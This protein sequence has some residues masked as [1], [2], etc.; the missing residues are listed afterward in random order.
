MREHGLGRYARFRTR[1]KFGKFSEG[2]ILAFVREFYSH[3]DS[4][5]IFHFRNVQTEEVKEWWLHDDEPIESWK[6]YFEVVQF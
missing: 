4:T 3:Y 5:T 2:E 1:H 6:D